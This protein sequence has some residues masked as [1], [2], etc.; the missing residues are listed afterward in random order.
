MQEQQYTQNWVA[1]MTMLQ[2]FFS[3]CSVLALASASGTLCDSRSACACHSYDGQ[4][5][6]QYLHIIYIYIYIYIEFNDVTT[7]TIIKQ[8]DTNNYINKFIMHSYKM[9]LIVQAIFQ[10]GSAMKNRDQ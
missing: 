3:I 2:S 6:K 7:R 8:R 1:I 10:S 9:K 4:F 5:V